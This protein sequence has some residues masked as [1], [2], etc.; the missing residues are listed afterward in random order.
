MCIRFRVSTV[1][2]LILTLMHT[3][4]VFNNNNSN[5]NNII[6]N[7]LTRYV[8]CCCPEQKGRNMSVKAVDLT[9]EEKRLF[10]DGWHKH[11]HNEY[12]SRKISIRRML[13]DVRDIE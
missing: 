6:N 7:T 3:I 8:T 13:P 11:A 4:N 2:V 10:E 12:T 1:F 9:P 5:T